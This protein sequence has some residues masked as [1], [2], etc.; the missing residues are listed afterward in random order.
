LAIVGFGLSTEAFLLGLGFLAVAGAADVISAVFRGTILQASVPDRLR[1]RLS[2]IHFAVVVGGPR[3]GD[4]EAGLVAH[5][6]SPVFSVIS[7]G[8]ACVVGII[9]LALLIPQFARYHAGDD[10]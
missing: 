9:V 4:T 6:T 3:L 1:G 2:S 10:L 8:A 5:L 7:G